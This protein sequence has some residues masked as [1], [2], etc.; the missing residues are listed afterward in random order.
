[1]LNQVDNLMS[2]PYIHDK[3]KTPYVN[4]IVEKNL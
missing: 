3:I 2:D 4:I 1:M